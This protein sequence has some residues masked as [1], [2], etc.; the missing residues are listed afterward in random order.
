MRIAAAIL[1]LMILAAGNAQ[2]LS[3]FPEGGTGITPEVT[4]LLAKASPDQKTIR[5]DDMVFRVETLTKS[6][7]IGDIW[8]SGIVYYNF[9]SHLTT[10][11]CNQWRAAAAT[12]SQA[13][14]LTFTEV[15]DPPPFSPYI[16]VFEGDGN[17]S[18]VGYQGS[19]Q[20]MSIV[21]WDYIY[22]IAH[23]IC[24]ALGFKHEHSRTDRDNYVQINWDNI[25]DDEEYNFEIAETINLT[26]YDFDSVMHY[27]ACDF[28]W[29]FLPCP[30]YYSITVLPPFNTVWQDSI[31][32]RTHL[33]ADDII[34]MGIVYGA[35]CH[36]PIYVDGNA[37]GPQNGSLLFPFQSLAMAVGFS[38]PGAEIRL[39]PGYHAFAPITIADQ[40]LITA[41][42][43]SAVVQ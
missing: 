9:D 25:I 43:G 38:C 27:A 39:L 23:E 33:S 20:E 42:Q 36:G 3:R 13:A 12:W 4:A 24:H 37:V 19:R 16:Y 34:G 32:Q 7:F 31:G 41:P 22:V 30:P 8:P 1:A 18:E 29:D 10:Y 14:N 2:A 17:W 28:V 26:D 35:S 40:V 5:I 11:E 15:T 6:G 21:S